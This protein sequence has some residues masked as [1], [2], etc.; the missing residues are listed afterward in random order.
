MPTKI[1]WTD[2]PWN[3]TTGCDKVSAGCKHCYAEVIT[4]R[5]PKTFPNGFKFTIRRDRFEQPRRWRS[6]RMVFV[7]SMSDLF[8]E[9]MP[10]D[11]LKELFAV[12]A[13]CPQHTFQILTKRHKR[14]AQLAPQLHWSPNIWMGVSIEN[15]NYATRADCLRQVPAAVRFISAEPLIGPLLLNVD[16][17]H[18]VIVGGESQLGCRPMDI[19]WARA[20]RDQCREAGVAYFLKQLG[21]HPNERGLLSDFPVDLRIREWPARVVQPELFDLKTIK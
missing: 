6:P 9:R 16:D 3:P 1:Q 7:N 2:E 14:L 21:G 19:A 4:H 11:V 17:I 20:I 10:L 15:Q 12:M 8:H 5:W 13:D 18:W